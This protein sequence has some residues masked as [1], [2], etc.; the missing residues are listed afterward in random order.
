MRTGVC[1]NQL[2]IEFEEYKFV[3]PKV[4][5]STC[6]SI[7]MEDRECAGFRFEY[8]RKGCIFNQYGKFG[9]AITGTQLG[10]RASLCFKRA[11]HPIFMN[12]DGLS[13]GNQIHPVIVADEEFQS[14]LRA[15]T[16]YS[17][18]LPR[19]IADIADC[20]LDDRK[21]G[22]MPDYA[23]YHNISCHQL[24]T[25][26]QIDF[27]SAPLQIELTIH[28]NGMER[29]ILTNTSEPYLT[30]LEFG[31]EFDVSFAD[32]KSFECH[33]PLFPSL[34]LQVPSSPTDENGELTI[35]HLT[36][37][38]DQ[39]I[40]SETQTKVFGT[41]SHQDLIALAGCILGLVTIGFCCFIFALRMRE[42]VWEAKQEKLL[43][44]Y[45][46]QDERL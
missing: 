44:D 26:L 2:G 16:V 13:L 9:D 5:V 18:F 32:S 38:C 39:I 35:I 6:L 24:K 37:S 31:S 30:G 12:F 4:N 7:C 19:E 22:V 11:Y 8:V 41:Y 28:E 25:P 36:V 34:P 27:I 29:I 45:K 43:E 40:T 20:E 1:S 17:L 33:L 42:Y 46:Y 23:L 21:H 14:L 10:R 15:G 3:T